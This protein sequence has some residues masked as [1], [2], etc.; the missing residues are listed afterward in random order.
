M[1]QEDIEFISKVKLNK[2]ILK[3]IITEEHYRGWIIKA[4]YKNPETGPCKLNY[5]PIDSR[6]GWS[7]SVT[8]RKSLA[9]SKAI[10]YKF[11]KGINN[12]RYNEVLGS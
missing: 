9:T 3:T 7:I 12:K 1:K 6:I 5:Y 8:H 4:E 11:I 10:V 2:R